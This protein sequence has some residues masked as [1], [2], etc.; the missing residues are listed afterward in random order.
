MILCYPEVKMQIVNE[1]ILYVHK[2]VGKYMYTLTKDPK[3]NFAAEKS[4]PD[5]LV[6]SRYSNQIW[7]ECLMSF[8]LDKA[9]RPIYKMWC[10]RW[11]TLPLLYCQ[12]RG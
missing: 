7:I 1:C 8:P 10:S 5:P 6:D 4:F 3:R 11:S 12:Y 9:L 2:N